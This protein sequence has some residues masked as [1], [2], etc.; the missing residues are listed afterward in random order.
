MLLSVVEAMFALGCAGYLAATREAV[1]GLANLVDKEVV[2][3][4]EMPE[5]LSMCLPQAVMQ[6]MGSGEGMEVS[7]KATT[8]LHLKWR[9]PAIL[10]SNYLPDYVNTGNNVGRR[11][12]TFQFSS[13]PVATPREGLE[14]EI[15]ATELPAVVCRALRAY[16]A[17]RE[18][19]AA[20]GGGFS[21]AMPAT[22]LGWKSE[23]AGATN[24]LHR[25]L[26]MQDDERGCTIRRCEGH[27]TWME[28][29]EAAFRSV[30]AGERFVKDAAVLHQF[31]FRVAKDENV[32]RGCKQLAKSRGG[33]CCELYSQRNRTKRTVVVDMLLSDEPPEIDSEPHLLD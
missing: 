22:M 17:L 13:R 21:R 5:R 32:C 24:A 30:M 27:V 15:V 2:I 31:G 6:S 12:V 1:F 29:L 7:R 25:F 14:D 18:R 4:R 9:V 28:D 10:A 16:H 20:M 11:L 8:A 19:V 33:K 26:S 23:L 3:G